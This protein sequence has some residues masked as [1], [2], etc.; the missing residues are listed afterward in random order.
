MTSIIIKSNT[1]NGIV[2]LLTSLDKS[3]LLPKK[4][5]K[6][7]IKPNLVHWL[8]YPV[9]T[10]PEIV[11]MIIEFF[12]DRVKKIIIAEGSASDT[13]KC[14]KQLGYTH[15]EKEGIELIDLN[16]CETVRLT[17]PNALVLK[18]FYLP[19][20]V[21]DGYLISLANLKHHHITK[22]T[23]TLKNMFGIAPGKY[24]SENLRN[25]PWQ[26]ER[27]H[28]IGVEKS[29]VDINMYRYP[30]L[31]IVD[32]RVA[33]LE[34]EQCGPTK[35]V[36]VFIGGDPAEVDM[37][38]IPFLGYKNIMYVEEI[39]KRRMKIKMKKIKR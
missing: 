36:G 1:Q 15:F 18:E 23:L 31:G 24:Y 20:V 21:K 17:N 6:L 9:T 38:G 30:D 7:I 33:Q 25:K 5:D 39:Y 4:V 29:I 10:D 32:G 26:K 35:K 34:N 13:W 27:L 12:S 11:R 19:K 3:H 2:Q 22:V 14:Y 8:P 16:D 37:I 28:D